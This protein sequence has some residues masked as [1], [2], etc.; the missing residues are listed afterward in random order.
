MKKLGKIIKELDLEDRLDEV[1]R[2]N[3]LQ[4]GF[5]VL[6]RVT[7]GLQKGKLTLIG[8]RPSMGKTTLALNI[9]LNSFNLEK[10]GILIFS[11]EL[12][13]KQL[14]IRLLKTQSKFQDVK[15]NETEN[16]LL[17][18]NIF[19]DDTS[20]LSIFE[21]M[22]RAA[23]HKQKNDVDLIIIDYLQLVESA[24]LNRSRSKNTIQ[25]FEI[26]TQ[27]LQVLAE[28]LNIP[29]LLLS[30]LPRQI[31]TRGGDKRPRLFD[32]SE[33]GNIES[34]TDL[35]LFLYRPGYYGITINE[36]GEDIENQSELIISKNRNGKTGTVLLK[37]DFEKAKFW[38]RNQY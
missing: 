7:G 10:V 21:I 25:N 12:S 33:Y 6:D 11:L 3:G 24:K 4:T 37:H 36:M 20:S 13:A 31:E 34:F 30:Q 26:I 5:K 9:A 38:E 14:A 27:M 32:L 8:G 15:N 23:T 29:I 1:G 35:V 16:T 28:S 19:I 2:I 17:S 22:N 18:S